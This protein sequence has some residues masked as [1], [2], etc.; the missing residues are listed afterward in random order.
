MIKK[1]R[2]I[3]NLI[4]EMK[5]W[6]ERGFITPEQQKAIL[7]H[8]K[9]EPVKEPAREPSKTE[10]FSGDKK[11]EV[12]QKKRTYS[13]AR[14]VTGLAA[15][16]LAAGIILFYAANW[17]KMPPALKLVQVFAL[18]LTVYGSAFFFL[19]PKRQKPLIGSV[20]LILGI[21]SYG[22]G[23]F[24]VAQ[25]YHISSHPANGMLAWALGA[26]V[27]SL[28]AK[29]RYACY[30][31]AGLFFIWNI[32]EVFFFGAAG[33]TF[34]IP[35]CVITLFLLWI[36][37][38]KG[39]IIA[40]ALVCWYIFQISFYWIF[41]YAESGWKAYLFV[42][43]FVVIGGGFH[44]LS[45]FLRSQKG[46]KPTSMFLTVCG[47]GMWFLPY[48][49]FW[50]IANIFGSPILTGWA[51]PVWGLAL[52]AA[53]TFLKKYN[54]YYAAMAVFFFW[55]Y[56]EHLAGNLPWFYALAM[57]LT[58]YLFYGIKNKRGITLSAASIFWFLFVITYYFTDVGSSAGMYALFF[59]AF[60]PAGC[61]A[62]CCGRMLPNDDITS[63]GKTILQAAGWTFFLIPFFLLSWPFN[64]N[65]LSPL[66]MFEHVSVSIEYLV[67]LV[68]SAVF[69][70]LLRKRGELIILESVPFIFALV[71]FFLPLGST[72][73]RMIFYHLGIIILIV[74]LLYLA[75]SLSE[76]YKLERIVGKV[77]F[78]AILLVKVTGFLLYSGI[79]YDF[80]LAYLA[81]AVLFVTVCFLLNRL[82]DYYVNDTDFYA[83]GMDALCAFCLWFSVYLSSFKVTGQRS[84]L[85]AGDIVLV[86]SVLFLCIAVVLYYVLLKLLKNNRLMIILS[87]IVLLFSIITILIAGPQIPWTLYSVI[88]NLLLLGISVTYI[89]YSTVIQSK[90]LLNIAI[91]AFVLHVL[92]RYFDLFWDM[93]SGSLFFI[94]TG[95]IGLFGGYFLEKNR[96]NLLAKMTNLS[97]GSKEQP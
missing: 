82:I 12:S 63:G 1:K 70:W 40:A 67:L 80:H 66:I 16:C 89:Y 4:L 83:K 2:F 78:P 77:F 25:I 73:L 75:R 27:M 91:A 64:A 62:V 19:D 3:S 39:I 72:M 31:S 55:S 26:L 58:G 37:D 5:E 8:Y 57:L 28:I 23:I 54:G 88:F 43:L 68:S 52:L 47:W 87:F 50:H 20:M 48:I 51:V 65:E 32:W 30:L 35:L 22:A 90:M 36:N 71:M 42:C 6:V 56:A 81:G 94:V 86:L 79:Q 45:A 93:L 60:L 18:L 33:Y 17:R 11:N 10:T 59:T 74:V 97:D 44:A 29:E 85:D 38:M 15:L 84:I 21:I 92:T 69:I 13:F 96:K 34:I 14:I 95:F 53:S 61:F 46:F 41:N 9:A 49:L 76:Q 7:V 24:L